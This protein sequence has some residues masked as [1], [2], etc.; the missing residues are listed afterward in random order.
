MKDVEDK[1]F[2]LM[3]LFPIQRYILQLAVT[4]VSRFS[5][6]VLYIAIFGTV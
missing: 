1:E 4:P 6:D 2:N 5:M 3:T